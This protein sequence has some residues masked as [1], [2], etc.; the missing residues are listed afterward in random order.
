MLPGCKEVL[1][2][3]THQKRALVPITGGCEPP[4]GCWELNSAPLKE[5][6]LLLISEPSLQSLVLFIFILCI[7]VFCL[8]CVL[9][10]WSYQQLWA[11]A[12]V[13]GTK[14]RSLT[15]S[16]A[17]KCWTILQPQH[18]TTLL[19]LIKVASWWWHTPMVAEEARILWVQGQSGL[20]SKF[21]DS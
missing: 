7:L 15:G 21:Q 13:L 10:L 5:W 4:C 2:F 18:H 19:R 12:W 1:L 8:P 14:P 9:V 17:L 16:S 6:S 11:A 3:L 20:Q